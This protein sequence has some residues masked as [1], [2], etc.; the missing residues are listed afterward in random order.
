MMRQVFE[1]GRRPRLTRQVKSAVKVKSMLSFT[2]NLP[3]QAKQSV[4]NIIVTFYGNCMKVCEDFAP[5]FG[6]KRIDCCI[7]TTHSLTVPFSPVN[8]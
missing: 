8:F 7:M 2:K 5:I 6:D 3:R 4:P 1:E